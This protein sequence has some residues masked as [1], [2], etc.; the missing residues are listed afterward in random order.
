MTAK[1]IVRIHPDDRVEVKVEG[2]S[3]GDRSRPKGKKLCDKVTKK[4]ESDLGL[5]LARQ[6]EDEGEQEQEIEFTQ[7]K[8]LELGGD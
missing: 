4:L 2:L 7:E 3:N 5:V 8:R 6:Y 1:L